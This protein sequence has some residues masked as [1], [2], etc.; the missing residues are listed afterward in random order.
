MRAVPRQRS[1]TIAQTPRASWSSAARAA[2][3]KGTEPKLAERIAKRLSRSG[4]CSR[5]I[6]EE[7]VREGRI[8]IDGEVV[9]DP[10]T[11]V[12]SA[13]KVSVDGAE[14]CRPWRCSAEQW[15]QVKAGPMRLWIHNKK[16]G[17]TVTER[18][19]H[20]AIPLI[21]TLQKLGL[22]RLQPVV[23]R[24]YARM[25]HFTHCTRGV[26]TSTR[27]ASCSCMTL[28]FSRCGQLAYDAQH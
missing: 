11:C 12:T 4:V 13:Q 21:P 9:R 25:I 27:R 19:E 2:P 20:A 17:V 16:P 1:C 28:I 26:S 6:G 22:P 24:S 8:R 3:A 18:D 10:A 23:R 15:M 7:W 5:R 14:V